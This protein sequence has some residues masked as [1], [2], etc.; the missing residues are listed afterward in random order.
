MGTMSMLAHTDAQLLLVLLGGGGT[1]LVGIPAVVVAFI[2]PRRGR[3]LGFASLTISGGAV[4][5]M[6][7]SAREL[8]LSVRFFFW[9]GYLWGPPLLLGVIALLIA[10]W[11]S[12]SRGGGS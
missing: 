6:L 4:L 8:G 9:L 10:S 2:A 1:L 7:V 5:V 3:W 12:K 11:R